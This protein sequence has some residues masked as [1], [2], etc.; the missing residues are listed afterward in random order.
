M[1]RFRVITIGILAL[2]L[3]ANGWL[4]VRLYRNSKVLQ[5]ETASYSSFKLSL[6]EAM[7]EIDSAI[8]DQPGSKI[9]QTHI[10]SANMNINRA[11]GLILGL[12][13]DLAK[14]GIDIY[15]IYIALAQSE[16]PVPS[17]ASVPKGKLQSTLIANSKTLHE[18][19]S[20]L[21][22]ASFTNMDLNKL[23]SA[24]KG[25]DEEYPGYPSYSSLQ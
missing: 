22:P 17:E 9:Q 21:N 16:S 7:E 15:P 25:L 18:L 23:R 14:E 1:N 6:N 12:R 2:S 24:V 20:A 4:G 8:K 13:T 11:M 5:M 3:F 19:H 10:V